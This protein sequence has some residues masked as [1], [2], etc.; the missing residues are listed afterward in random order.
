MKK[1]ITVLFVLAV[2]WAG[3]EKIEDLLTFQFSETVNFTVPSSITINAP[4]TIQTPP[5][6]SSSTTEFEQNNTNADKVRDIQLTGLTLNITSP[7]N[8]TFSFLNSIELYITSDG[9]PDLLIASRTD[10]PNNI[11]QSLVVP[12]NNAAL[13]EYVK[14][15]VYGIRT[16]VETDETFFEDVDIEADLSFE[17]TADPL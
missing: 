4:V 17:V 16:D 6:P 14:D 8:R 1:G 5:Q 13:D 3:C 2:L 11:G 12:T 7:A 10:I 9:L 15:G